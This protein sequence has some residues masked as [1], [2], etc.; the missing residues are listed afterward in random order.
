M[1]L[2][3]DPT[4]STGALVGHAGYILLIVSML[5][6]RMLWLRI[7]AIGAGVLQALYYGVWLSD[8]VGTFW[9]TIFT[10]TN[11]GQLAFIAYRNSTARFTADER[12]FYETAVPELEAA[13]ARRLIAKG[14]WVTVEPGTVLTREGENAPML[15]FI[16][17]GEV[18]ISVNG[19]KVGECGPGTFVGEISVSSNLPAS[20]TA[21]DTGPL[22]WLRP[23]LRRPHDR[24]A[25]RNRPG[26]GA[27]LPSRSSRQ[28][29]SDQCRNGNRVADNAMNQTDEHRRARE[30]DR[31]EIWAKRTGRILGFVVLFALALYLLLTYAPR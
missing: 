18:D 20:A 26:A 4:L 2:D 15:A 3:L 19:R 6:T 23:R 31:I 21:T 10:L 8:P 13:D 5:M 1:H 25:R 14:R 16:V 27:C 17:S 7:I 29:A 28:A 22:P 24:Q 12:A 30:P 9:E 11:V